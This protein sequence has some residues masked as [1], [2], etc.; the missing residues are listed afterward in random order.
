MSELNAIPD[1]AVV[2]EDGIITAAST[3]EVCAH[4]NEAN[5]QVIDASG[6]AVLPAVDSHTH[7]VFG[8]LSR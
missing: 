1:G 2:I 4:L 3:Q 6:K 8:G 5:Y 7:L